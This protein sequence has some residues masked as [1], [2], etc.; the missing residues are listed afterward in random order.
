MG[1]W[2]IP[3]EHAPRQLEGRENRD[4]HEKRDR[5]LN[6]G[7]NEGTDHPDLVSRSGNRRNQAGTQVATA[8]R[9]PTRTLARSRSRKPGE[10]RPEEG[11]TPSRLSERA[12]VGEQ[13][14]NAGLTA[15]GVIVVDEV[16][17]RIERYVLE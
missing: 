5:E 17:Q 9:T 3:H 15:R 4:P 7:C 8:A 1:R 13:R 16:R 14:R 10:N 6:A 12:W 2:I 11:V